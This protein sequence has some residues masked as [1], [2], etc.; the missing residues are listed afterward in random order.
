MMGLLDLNDPLLAKIFAPGKNPWVMTP[1]GNTQTWVSQ[2]RH[3]IHRMAAALG[4]VP[5]ESF[6]EEIQMDEIPLNYKTLFDGDVY[7]QLLKDET[8]VASPIVK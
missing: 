2:V 3:I 8:P 7:G 4:H 1:G 6:L 5:K